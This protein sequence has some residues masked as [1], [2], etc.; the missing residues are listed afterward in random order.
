MHGLSPSREGGHAIRSS[1]D[2]EHKAWISPLF[3]VALLLRYR[4]TSVC[5]CKS[6]QYLALDLRNLIN[7]S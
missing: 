1:K 4:Y 6:V 7:L 5:Q 3:K 2:R